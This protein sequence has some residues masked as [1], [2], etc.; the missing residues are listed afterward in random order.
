MDFLLEYYY[1]ICKRNLKQYGTKIIKNIARDYNGYVDFNVEDNRF[2]C[3]VVL[4]LNS[5]EKND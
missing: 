1:S 5:G 2:I 4:N 3:D